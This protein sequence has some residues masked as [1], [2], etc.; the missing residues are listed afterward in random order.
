MLSAGVLCEAMDVPL[1]GAH[2]WRDSHAGRSVLLFPQGNRRVR[3]Y[4]AYSAHAGYRLSGDS[5]LPRFIK[6]S[7]STGAPAAY[8]AGVKAIGP[9][10]TFAGADAWVVHPYQQGVALIGDAAAS[11]DPTW[12]QGVSLTV[13]DVRVLRDALLR[14]DNW[15]EAGRAYAEEH[16]RYYGALH[17]R[18]AWVTQMFMATGAEADALRA[19][20]MPLWQADPSRVPDSKSGPDWTRDE[21]ARKRF[22]G[23]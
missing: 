13:R 3:A 16:D 8:F 10:A 18:E 20:A 2:T 5:D 7:V 15:D 23:E 12:G 17:R 14:N 6:L 1:D 19:K 9:L 22:F 11:S 4:L 21:T